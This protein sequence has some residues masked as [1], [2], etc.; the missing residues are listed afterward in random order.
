MDR[1]SRKIILIEDASVMELNVYTAVNVHEIDAAL[2]GLAR[3]PPIEV[4]R[5]YDRIA[6][7]ASAAN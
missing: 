3:V 5:Y 6:I 2:D 1:Y 4:A 7:T